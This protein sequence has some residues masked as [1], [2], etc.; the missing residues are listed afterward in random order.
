MLMTDGHECRKHVT[1]GKMSRA[2]RVK[3]LRRKVRAD[4]VK[5]SL[6]QGRSGVG[7]RQTDL[8]KVAACM[9]KGILGWV[10]R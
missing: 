5:T 1:V 3:G 8:R 6:A 7:P 4:I 9:V 2:N 10:E